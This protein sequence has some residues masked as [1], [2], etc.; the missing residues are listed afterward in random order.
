MGRFREEDNAKDFTNLIK[1]RKPTFMS[2]AAKLQRVMDDQN[3]RLQVRK[4]SMYVLHE[5]HWGALLKDI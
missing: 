4:R 3:N 1:Q 2:I 5:K